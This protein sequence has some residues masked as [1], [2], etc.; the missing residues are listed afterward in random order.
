MDVTS[1][2]TVKWMII[3]D[4]LGGTIVIIRVLKKQRWES[5]EREDVRM[6][7]E[8]RLRHWKM[9]PSGFEDQVRRQ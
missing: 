1:L 5:L 7:A 9:L 6:K 3:L 8:V 4:C 2:R